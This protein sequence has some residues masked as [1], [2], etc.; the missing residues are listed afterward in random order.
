[1]ELV[2]LIQDQDFTTR[3]RTM[4]QRGA[5]QHVSEEATIGQR[6]AFNTVLAAPCAQAHAE[7]I[8]PTS[9]A[10]M[11]LATMITAAYA[12]TAGLHDQ[13]NG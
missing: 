6:E 10:G 9:A 5:A 2:T 8:D 4:A 1:M 3:V 7:G 13:W 12:E 11:A